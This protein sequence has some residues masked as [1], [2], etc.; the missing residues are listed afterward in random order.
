MKYR[1]VF[2]HFCLCGCV[3]V[4]QAFCTP[5][6]RCVRRLVVVIDEWK[7]V[8]FVVC[9]CSLRVVPFVPCL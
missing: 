5:L 1:P 8:A 3:F 2:K 7:H 4:G 6:T 9:L